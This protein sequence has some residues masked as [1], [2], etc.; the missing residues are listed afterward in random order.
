MDPYQDKNERNSSIKSEKKK[1]HSIQFNQFYSIHFRITLFF[2]TQ[3]KENFCWLFSA[4][5]AIEWEKYIKFILY[6]LYY[7][8]YNFIFKVTCIS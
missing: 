2:H 4:V 6:R 5:Q 8:M 7:I 1:N 3:K